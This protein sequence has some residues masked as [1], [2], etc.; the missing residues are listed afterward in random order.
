MRFF[1]AI[2]IILISGCTGSLPNNSESAASQTTIEYDKFKNLTVVKTPLYLSRKG[3]TDTFPVS[4]AYRAFFKKGSPAI[5]QL[6]VKKVGMDW[7]FYNEAFGEDGHKFNF[8]KIDSDVGSI[9]Y[10]VTTTEHFGLSID[11]DQLAAMS[12]KDYEIKVYGTRDSG[13][14]VVP[15]SLTQG[16]LEKYTCVSAGNCR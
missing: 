11:P 14:F 6:Y 7:G 3:F 16:F 15:A 9:G 13:S 8:L 4:I 10:M 5:I 2:A 12:E 1:L